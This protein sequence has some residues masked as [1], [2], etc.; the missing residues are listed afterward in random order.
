MVRCLLIFFFFADQRTS[1]PW[2]R[3]EVPA[4]DEKTLTCVGYKFVEDRSVAQLWERAAGRGDGG[5]IIVGSRPQR[6][7]IVGRV[8]GAT[9]SMRARCQECEKKRPEE[10]RLQLAHG[11]SALR[12]SG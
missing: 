8:V 10:M 6:V 3:P 12:T 2:R 1:R 5:V 9:C 11:G 7:I 4:T